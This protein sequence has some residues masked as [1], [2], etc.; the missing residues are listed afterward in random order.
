MHSCECIELNPPMPATLYNTNPQNRQYNLQVNN[1][2]SFDGLCCPLLDDVIEKFLW[3]LILQNRQR[4][5]ANA[6][7][8]DQWQNFIIQLFMETVVER[9]P[10]D[11]VQPEKHC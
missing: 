4:G 9:L 8:S 6:E 5:N 1:Y 11:A 10:T 3:L 2:F 7:L